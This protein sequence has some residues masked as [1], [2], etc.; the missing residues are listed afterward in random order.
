VAGAGVLA[1]T[2]VLEHEYRRHC[3]HHREIHR[4]EHGALVAAAVAAESHADAPLSAVRVPQLAGDRGAY[5]ERR[6]GADDGVGSEHAFVEIRD[7][8]RATL[9]LAET[10]TP[11]VDLLHHPGDVAP[12]GDA[13]PVPAVSAHDVVLVGQVRADTD[14]DGFLPGIE[15]RE[16]R[17][18][19]GGNLDVQA[20]LELPDR[21][22][23]PVGSEQP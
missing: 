9:A 1:V 21:P 10:V 8:H 3:E 17:N 2:I 15:M 18:L 11:P 23:A 5:G 14:R 12:F 7:V 16:A 20:L 6:P 13:V 4:L 22:H 19:A